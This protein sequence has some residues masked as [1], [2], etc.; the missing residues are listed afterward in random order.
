MSPAH[1]SCRRRRPPTAM[2]SF[3]SLFLLVTTGS[4]CDRPPATAPD[5]TPATTTAPAGIDRTI[6]ALLLEDVPNCELVLDGPAEVRDLRTNAVL[7]ALAAAPRAAVRFTDAGVAFGDAAVSG[8]VEIV[9]TGSAPLKVVM[10]RGV[11]RY[12][13]RLRLL[14]ERAGR[15]TVVNVVDIE[16]Y[17]LGVV[18][19][20]MPGRFHPEAFRAQAIAARTYAWY[21]K[22]TARP[23]RAW[24]V[25][26]TESSQMYL[27]LPPSALTGESFRAVRQTAGLV[28]TWAS[29]EGERLFCTYY[30]STCGGSTQAAGPVKREQVI[31]PLAGG[32]ACEWCRHSPDFRWEPV[33]LPKARITSALRQRYSR[34]GTIGDVARVEV[35]ERT[36]CGRPVR[37]EFFDEAGGSIDLEAENFRLAVDPT[38]REIRSTFFTP[39]V[40]PD[41]IVL[42]EGR[43]FGHGIGLCQYGADG[44][45][46]AGHSAADI[47]AF[48]YPESHITRAY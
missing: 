26:S 8:P 7:L 45:G 33:C 47:L 13:G 19:A 2:S 12:R 42:T 11:L 41:A 25:W 22:Q 38:G 6:R 14:P 18:S 5:S 34:F 43:G 27:G 17:L 48:Y 29:P 10:P 23:G 28:C 37:L 16:E 20:E 31:P 44:M 21:A 1:C 3:C 35:V 39:V 36:P 40:E 32:V 4:G 24:D 15:G 46:R 30:S 9:P